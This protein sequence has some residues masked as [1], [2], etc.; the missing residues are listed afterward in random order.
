[1][2]RRLCRLGGEFFWVAAGQG[3]LNASRRRALIAGLDGFQ[4][5]L[6][7]ICAATLVWW[8]GPSSSLAMSGYAIA[9]S[10]VLGFQRRAVHQTLPKTIPTTIDSLG[11]Q[12]RWKARI[13]RY[14]WPFAVWG[15][16]LTLQTASARWSL[17][18]FQAAEIV[19]FSAVLYQV[20]HY[21]VAL[22]VGSLSKFLSPV[23]FNRA[24][25]H[26]G[27]EGTRQALGL[28]R[29][30]VASALGVTFIATGTAWFSHEWIFALLVAPEYR[31]VSWLL[32]AQVLA[33]GLLV[34]AQVASL[35][36][37]VSADSEGLLKPKLVSAGLGT[38]L[39]IL[40][41]WLLGLAGVVYA[42]VIYGA[43]SY[44]WIARVSSFYRFDFPSV[45]KTFQE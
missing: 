19:G 13:A 23:M 45:R 2:P 32:P 25:E 36:P 5:S 20:A 6:R 33:S 14:G 40:G 30:L 15:A 29:L 24:G 27:S 7:F 9:A 11:A 34:A 41:A 43:I 44:L 31:V 12:H 37:M 22:L 18:F 35:L 16:A 39:N 28:G 1:M 17:Q 10:L 4:Q 42:S 26:S 3:V 38:M 21:P 8:F